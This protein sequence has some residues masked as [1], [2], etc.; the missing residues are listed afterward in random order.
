MHRRIY[1]AA[2]GAIANLRRDLFIS[3]TTIGV[4]AISFI[5]LGAFVM[6]YNNMNSFLLFWENN[7]HIEA[8]FREGSQATI[9]DKTI[10]SLGNYPEISKIELISSKEALERFRKRLGEMDSILE[11]LDKNPL[12]PYLEITLKEGGNNTEGISRVS[13]KIREISAIDEVVYGHEWVER[14]S[15]FI[16]LTRISGLIA[17]SFLIVATILI[18]SNTIRL[19]VYAR[20]E[21]LEIMRLLGA[22]D[23]YI[24]APFIMEGLLQGLA[25]AS[26]SVISLYIIYRFL[27]ASISSHSGPALVS[28]AAGSFEVNFL[29]LS[30]VLYLMTGG[31]AVGITGSFVSLGRF[32]KV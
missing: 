2:T 13:E 10:E 22:T 4:I 26:L 24:K 20:K 19:T 6:A 9:I 21:E 18:V 3:I 32:L 12:P 8:Y 27:L 14:F 16:A 31:M 1:K 15:A 28:M 30:M 23:S 7:I 5:I 11:G 29:S 25:G 17:L